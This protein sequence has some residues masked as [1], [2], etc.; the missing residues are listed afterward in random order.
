VTSPGRSELERV[1]E[2]VRDDLIQP[3][4]IGEDLDRGQPPLDGDAS[5]IELA[6]EAA[7]GRGDVRQ[8]LAAQPQ[9]EGSRVGGGQRLQVASHARQQHLIP[10]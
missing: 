5:R 3:A 1:G 10:Q 8:V 2:Q 6:R 4:S 9:V 7:G